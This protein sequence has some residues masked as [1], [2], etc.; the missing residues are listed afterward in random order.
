M[1]AIGQAAGMGTATPGLVVLHAQL[2]VSS[3][4]RPLAGSVEGRTVAV[5]DVRGRGQFVCRDAGAYSWQS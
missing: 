1:L 3:V 2:G 4:V 5:P